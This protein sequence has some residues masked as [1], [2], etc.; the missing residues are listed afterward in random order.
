[1]RVLAKGYDVSPEPATEEVRREAHGQQAERRLAGVGRPDDPDPL[2]FGDAEVDVAERFPR[3]ARVGVG[4]LGE[5][6]CR[7]AHR[8]PR[9]RRAMAA[10]TSASSSQRST[11][12]SGPSAN[13]K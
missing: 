13:S 7:L 2:P 8:Q 11:R 10:G 1:E 12:W 6:Q 3:R 5:S 9:I 4:D